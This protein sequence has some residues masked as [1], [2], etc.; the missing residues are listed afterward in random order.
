MRVGHKTEYGNWWGFL[1]MQNYWWVLEFWRTH[2]KNPFCC[3]FR[4]GKK[5]LR[6]FSFC[7]H[8]R[9]QGKVPSTL[10][11]SESEVCDLEQIFLSEADLF[12]SVWVLVAQLCPALCDPVDCSPPASSLHRILQARILEWI[13]ILF[14][15]GSSRPRD[16]T[17]VSCIPAIFFTIWA[18]R[19]APVKNI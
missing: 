19:E 5:S 18:T 15:S 10:S 11:G 1:N 7:Q 2:T 8:H 16:Q 4:S 3:A 6:A 17:R 13:A 9:H 14:F 12:D